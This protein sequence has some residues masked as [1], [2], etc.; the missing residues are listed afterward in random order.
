M[1][2]KSFRTHQAVMLPSGRSFT[3][4]HEGAEYQKA[5]LQDGM[6]VIDGTLFVPLNN[7]C[8]FNI[9]GEKENEPQPKQ[10]PLPGQN[11]SQSIRI[12]QTKK[13]RGSNPRVPQPE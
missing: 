9:L 12:E 10:E 4:F 6:I 2:V 1:N 11:I 8:F 13:G 7:V 5:Y 3:L